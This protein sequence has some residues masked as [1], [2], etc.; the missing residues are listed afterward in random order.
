M[1]T[2]T[3]QQNTLRTYFGLPLHEAVQMVEAA[4][5]LGYGVT[6]CNYISSVDGQAINDDS[7]VTE[8][9]QVITTGEIP[10]GHLADDERVPLEVL[11]SGR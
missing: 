9:W 4:Q 8:H 11:V 7:S 6:L 5:H 3:H 1:T 2:T 10:E